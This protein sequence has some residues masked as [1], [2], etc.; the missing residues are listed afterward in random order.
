MTSMTAVVTDFIAAGGLPIQLGNAAHGFAA[1]GFQIDVFVL[2]CRVQ[3]SG[4][5]GNISL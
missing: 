4:S 3:G 2:L 5:A 1:C